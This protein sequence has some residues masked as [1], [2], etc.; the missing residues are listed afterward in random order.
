MGNLGLGVVLAPFFL[1]SV[2]SGRW[3]ARRLVRKEDRRLAA[4]WAWVANAAS[5]LLILAALQPFF[6]F[7]LQWLDH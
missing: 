2:W 3:I 6:R 7:T 4:R 1:L 5:Y